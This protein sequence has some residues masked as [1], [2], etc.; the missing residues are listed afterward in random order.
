MS[1]SPPCSQNQLATSVAS[2]TIFRLTKTQTIYNASYQIKRWRGYPPTYWTARGQK[3]PTKRH[4]GFQP[5]H[6][7]TSKQD[8]HGLPSLS[9]QAVL[10]SSLSLYQV[11]EARPL[12]NLL[13]IINNKL[14]TCTVQY[15]TDIICTAPIKCINCLSALHQSDDPYCP[16]YIDEMIN[17]AIQQKIPFATAMSTLHP[18]PPP[19]PTVI[20][21]P[22]EKWTPVREMVSICYFVLW[23]SY[24]VLIISRAVAVGPASE[25]LMDCFTQLAEKMLGWLFV[26]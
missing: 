14:Q 2:S 20:V 8:I 5:W 4:S 21:Q 13:Q 24:Q 7:P 1:T 19:K 26:Q 16:K 3:S 17:L 6:Q 15:C 12:S 18:P 10:L 9:R 25:N 23:I 11:S 22:T